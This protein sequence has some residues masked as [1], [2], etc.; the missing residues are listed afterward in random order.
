MVSWLVTW[1]WGPPPAPLLVP[2]PGEELGLPRLLES[3]TGSREH[4]APPGLKDSLG[5]LSGTSSSSCP[6]E[7]PLG[8]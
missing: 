6:E 5:C 2:H 8:V 1:C 7:L 3:P 4:L